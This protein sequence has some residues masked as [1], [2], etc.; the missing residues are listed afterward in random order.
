[1]AE[2]QAG[3]VAKL[4]GQLHSSE[5]IRYPMYASTDG[6]GNDKELKAT[7]LGFYIKYLYKV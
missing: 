4:F 2:T 7:Q 5:P 6:Q 3:S 1:M